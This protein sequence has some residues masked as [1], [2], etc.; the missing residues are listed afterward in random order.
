MLWLNYKTEDVIVVE[1]NRYM[2]WYQKKDMDYNSKLHYMN[3]W[4]PCRGSTS[5]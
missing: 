1:Y 3:K 5:N 2:Y 4:M